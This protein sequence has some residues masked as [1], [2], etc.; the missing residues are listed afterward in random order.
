[1]AED[2]AWSAGED[3]GTGA[4]ERG[5][6]WA[7]DG[8]DAGVDAVQAS[9]ADSVRDCIIGQPDVEQLAA[10]DVAVLTVGDRRDCGVVG[11]FSAYT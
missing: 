5:P 7:A 3:G 4:F 9:G 6:W 10:R 11:Y 2:G 1:V 8:V